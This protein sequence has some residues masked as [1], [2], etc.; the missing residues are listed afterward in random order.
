MGL[1]APL[2]F[3]KTKISSET[4]SFHQKIEMI[5]LKNWKGW[6]KWA[7][8][9]P[10][11]IL[12]PTIILKQ[13]TDTKTLRWLNWS[14]TINWWVKVK[15]HNR[16]LCH[17]LP[18]THRGRKSVC[19]FVYSPQKIWNHTQRK[20]SVSMKYDPV[21]EINTRKQSTNELLW[22]ELEVDCLSRK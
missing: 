11:P 21:N 1:R 4:S 18:K 7:L 15:P 19:P 14:Q 17:D 2:G 8:V 16:N 5:A 20:V 3:S 13:Q 12:K 10:W 22:Y 6:T 9:P